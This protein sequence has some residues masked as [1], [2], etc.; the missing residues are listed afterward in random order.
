MV[1]QPRKMR[2]IFVHDA[3][4]TSI[5]LQISLLGQSTKKFATV[6]FSMSCLTRWLTL[7]RYLLIPSEASPICTLYKVG[8]SPSQWFGTM[9]S[10]NNEF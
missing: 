6:G 10:P 1:I 3:N 2:L 7:Y 8:L 4:V 9:V 5:W